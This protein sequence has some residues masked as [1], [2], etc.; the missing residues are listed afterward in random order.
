MRSSS[1]C[2]SLDKVRSPLS[3]T[4]AS[5]TDDP[6]RG[7]ERHIEFDLGG[8][9]HANI[10]EDYLD[11]LSKHLR[12]ESTLKYVALPRLTMESLVRKNRVQA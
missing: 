6:N 4:L 7:T 5:D 3:S 1:L 8:L 11:R 10:S 9:P 2:T 12:F